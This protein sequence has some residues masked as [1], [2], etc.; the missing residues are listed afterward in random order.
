[1][2]GFE[3]LSRLRQNSTWA[4]MPVIVLSSAVLEAGERAM[5]RD[6]SLIMSKSE[7]ASDTLIGA[8]D[9]VLRQNTAA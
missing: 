8:I 5:L 2:N 6:A 4:D 7:L 9:S 3:F 1:M